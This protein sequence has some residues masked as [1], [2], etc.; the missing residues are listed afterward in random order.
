[1][2]FDALYLDGAGARRRAADAARRAAGGA[3]AGAQPRAAPADV[4]SRRPPR[5]SRSARSRSVTKGVMAKAVDGAYAAG[6]RGSGVA[7][8]EAGAHARS[9]RARGGVGQRTPARHAQQPASRRARRGARRLRD[10]RQ[11][12]QGADRRDAGVA[13][14]RRSSSSRS[15][16]TTT[17]STCAPR[18]SSR[19]RSTT[20]RR[21][22]SIPAASTL[23]FA[24]VKR[25]RSD[26]TAAEADTIDDGSVD[27][28]R[29]AKPWDDSERHLA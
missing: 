16:A 13:D 22:R 17:P 7:E 25:Y 26:K 23:R 19:S 27:R 29:S 24:R 21:A 18:W 5:R 14:D 28:I 3:G 9:R 20:C 8:G 6:R 12:V 2:F 1:M 4:R 11:D 15:A 10:A